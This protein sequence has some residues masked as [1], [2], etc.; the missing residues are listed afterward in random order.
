VHWQV[1]LTKVQYVGP[2]GE[3]DVRPVVDREQLAVPLTGIGEHLE[4]RQLIYSLKVFLTQL[5]DVYS[6]G[7]YSVEEL[8]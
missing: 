8:L 5:D 7:Q 3:G 2:G 4:R 1:A 6:T